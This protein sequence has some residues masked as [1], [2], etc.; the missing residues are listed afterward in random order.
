MRD[1]I[2]SIYEVAYGDDGT[3]PT[4]TIKVG[5][6]QEIC[7]ISSIVNK[8]NIKHEEK[9]PNIDNLSSKM[10]KLNISKKKV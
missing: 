10:K 1:T 8:L 5:S 4:T 6:E 7:D 3:N 9:I 2:G